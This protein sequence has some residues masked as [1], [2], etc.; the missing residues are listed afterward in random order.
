MAWTA[1]SVMPPMSPPSSPVVA[2]SSRRPPSSMIMSWREGGVTPAARSPGPAVRSSVS[3]MN[4]SSHSRWR[5]RASAPSEG[6]SLIQLSVSAR[7]DWAAA[8]HASTACRICVSHGA[9]RSTAVATCL[10]IAALASWSSA[11]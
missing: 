4:A 2:M 1:T 9:R 6:R 8:I 7:S 11:M 10:T 5:C 3:T